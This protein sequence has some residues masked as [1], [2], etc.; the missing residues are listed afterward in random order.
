MFNT[1]TY[2]LSAKNIADDYGITIST[3]GT[4][5]VDG[6][7]SGEVELAEDQDWFCALLCFLRKSS[8]HIGC[9]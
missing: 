8:S 7:V 9:D 5:S 3:A 1:G 4:L 6:S 2:K